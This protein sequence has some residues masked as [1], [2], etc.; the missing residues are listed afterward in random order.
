VVSPTLLVDSSVWI[1]LLRGGDPELR[2]RLAAASGDA[3]GLAM[4]EP[5]AMELL[6]GAGEQSLPRIQRLVEGLR[7]LEI[8][9]LV[10]F[11]YAAALWRDSRA[12]GRTVRSLL[13]CLIAAVAIRHDAVL[14]HRDRDFD[15]LAAVSP[16][17]T[18]RWD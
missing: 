1:S 11:R 4:T 10:D 5:V 16:L 2:E 17:R 3:G 8:D 13:D 15:A 9:P 6:A 14:V 12:R 18:E 7:V